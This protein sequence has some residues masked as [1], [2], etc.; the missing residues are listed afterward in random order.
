MK[1]AF[2]IIHTETDAH[3]LIGETIDPRNN[4][5]AA[6]DFTDILHVSK[7]CGAWIESV[8]LA[9]GGKNTGYGLH[10]DADTNACHA[11]NIHVESGRKGAIRIQGSRVTLI[12]ITITRP[13]KKYDIVIGNRGGAR[14]RE[15]TLAN[16]CRS[17]G[18]P[19]RI[20][21]GNADKPKIQNSH[22]EHLFWESIWL[23]T[24]LLFR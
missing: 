4:R 18:R 2:K 1:R 10:F 8:V 22:V 5:L 11:H 16:V 3:R 12:G 20:L 21:L 17:D 24:I 15:T 14:V 9:G 6:S 13:G 23:K 7:A 19:V